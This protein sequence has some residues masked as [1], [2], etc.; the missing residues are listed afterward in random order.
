MLDLAKSILALDAKGLKKFR[1]PGEFEY[2][3]YRKMDIVQ[4]KDY[5]TEVKKLRDFLNN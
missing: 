2:G 1:Y 4:P 3:S 5:E